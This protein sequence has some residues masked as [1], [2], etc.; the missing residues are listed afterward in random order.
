MD[1][2]PQPLIK[3]LL[4]FVGLWAI[5]VLTLGI[6]GLVIKSVLSP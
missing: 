4:W 1:Q 5:S 6:I 2:P 3:Q